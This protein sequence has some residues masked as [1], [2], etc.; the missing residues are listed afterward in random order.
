M[1]PLHW[2][3]LQTGRKASIAS[4]FPLVLIK[5]HET[6]APVDEKEMRTVGQTDR[7]TNRPSI[8]RIDP[9]QS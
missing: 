3:S 8:K 6:S 9:C 5:V 2:D 4:L 7:Q 1:E